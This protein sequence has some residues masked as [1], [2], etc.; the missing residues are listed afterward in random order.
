VRDAIRTL[1][2]RRADDALKLERLRLSVQA[3]AAALER[4]DCA[5]VGDTTLDDYIDALAAPDGKP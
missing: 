3:G 1:Q 5:D 4:G 2:R